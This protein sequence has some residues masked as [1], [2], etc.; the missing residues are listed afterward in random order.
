[1]RQIAHLM[2]FL[3]ALL[4]I[5]GAAIA[6]ESNPAPSP[7]ESVV[8]EYADTATDTCLQGLSDHD[9]AKY[10]EHANEDFT[11]AVTQEILDAAATKIDSQLGGYQTIE[12]LKTEEQEGYVIVHYRATYDKG[13]VGIRM[14]FDED[15]LIAGQWFE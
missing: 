6:C 5:G 11:A 4:T 15:Q 13:E 3:I 12:V 1:M 7:D 10:T 9:L 14:V 2:P 8:R